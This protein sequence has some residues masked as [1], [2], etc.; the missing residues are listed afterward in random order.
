MMNNLEHRIIY[1]L[2]MIKPI[3]YHLRSEIN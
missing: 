2:K 3:L 1:I